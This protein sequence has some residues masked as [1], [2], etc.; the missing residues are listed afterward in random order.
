MAASAR[1]PSPPLK[2]SPGGKGEDALRRRSRGRGRRA[3]RESR[4]L[5]RP[6]GAEA[7]RLG[8]GTRVGDHIDHGWLTGLHGGLGAFQGGAN[9]VR[10]LDVLTVT[11]KNLG[12]LVV[13]GE[14]E[15]A[16]GH[17]THGGPPPIVAHHDQDGN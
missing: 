10:L 11:S 16:T 8:A 13:A 4:A 7:H 1:S 15:V 12:E 5:N 3:V 9:L 6:V 14:T 2:P 17:A